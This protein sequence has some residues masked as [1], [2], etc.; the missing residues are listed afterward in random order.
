MVSFYKHDI[1]SWMDGTEGLSD[2]AYRVYHV[3]CQLIYLNEGPIAFNEHGIAGRCRQSIRSFRANLRELVDGGKLGLLDG[4]L[5]N[6]R[7]EKE[8]EKI[9]ENRLNAA[10]GGQKSGAV[11]SS[12]SKLLKNNDA[13]EAPL[14]EDRSL[15]EKRRLEKT[16][17]ESLLCAQAH[18]AGVEEEFEEF[19]RSYPKRLGGSARKPAKALFE[20]AVKRGVDPKKIIG[21]IRASVGFNPDKIGTEYIPHAEKWLRDRRYEDWATGP[22]SVTDQPAYLQAPPGAK[23]HAEIMASLRKATN[24]QEVATEVRSNAGVG[25]NGAGHDPELRIPGG[26]SLFPEI[27]RKERRTS[28][29]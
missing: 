2:G 8:L 21:A 19:W 3:V 1:P 17:E 26:S 7:A 28:D 12:S 5:R 4:R 18:G 16:R 25:S 15:K 14:P 23:S 10:K 13:S 24:G 27:Q 11:R 22:P 29:D 20:S 6:F 9:C